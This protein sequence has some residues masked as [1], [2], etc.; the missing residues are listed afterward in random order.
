MESRSLL[1]LIKN[2]LPLQFLILFLITLAF[3]YPATQAGFIWDDE[4]Y[5]IED[6]LMTASDGLQRIWFSPLEH[7]QIWYYIPFTRTSF[8]IEH[9]LWG[10]DLQKFHLTNIFLHSANSIVLWLV[11]RF[12]R[13]PGAWGIGLLFAIHPMH[14]ESVAWISERKNVLSGLF[15]LLSIWSYLYFI[16]NKQGAFYLLSLGLFVCALLSKPATVMLPVILLF[17]YWWLRHPIQ[18][19][20]IFLLIPFF[21][22]A[23]GEAYFSIWFELYAIG[24]PGS[25]LSLNLLERILIASHIPYFYLSKLLFPYPLL[26]NYPTFQLSSMQIENYL[27]LCSGILMTAVFG[28]KYL[29]W[30]RVF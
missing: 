11:L 7:N 21:L 18:K 28:W 24:S 22:C 9:Q 12:L 25:K 14:V 10:L 1:S 17:C 13:I 4:L 8:W 30:G 20:D 27:P 15:Y 2:N 29:K 23:L 6:P 3:Y 5:F 16:K 19:K 26:F